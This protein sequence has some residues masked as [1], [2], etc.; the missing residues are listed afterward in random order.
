MYESL[1]PMQC[2]KLDVHIVNFSMI[3][4]TYV[5]SDVASLHLYVTSC[6][7]FTNSLHCP[8]IIFTSLIY[9]NVIHTPCASQCISCFFLHNLFWFAASSE[10]HN[11]RFIKI[12]NS[13]S[14]LDTSCSRT[15]YYLSPIM[16]IVIVPVLIGLQQ[17][18]SRMTILSLLQGGSGTQKGII[19]KVLSHPHG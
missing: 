12:H 1:R 13:T 15:L 5:I 11:F 3:S 17:S 7:R 2:I 10:P 18:P 8:S 16:K 14:L 4:I 6:D 9:R 19:C